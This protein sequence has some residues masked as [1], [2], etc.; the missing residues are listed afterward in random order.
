MYTNFG[1]TDEKTLKKL[2]QQS[3]SAAITMAKQ[4]VSQYVNKH[5]EETKFPAI[6]EGD[7]KKVDKSN[8]EIDLGET[9][10]FRSQ[11]NDLSEEIDDKY[12]LS[13]EI[14]QSLAQAQ[15]KTESLEAAIPKWPVYGQPVA[16]FDALKTEF[17]Q[18]KS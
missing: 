9:A 4:A 18:V 14:P 7:L 1:K 10:D 13:E 8:V 6:K 5:P 11:I 3:E 15:Q 2:S 16:Q 17:N 12:V